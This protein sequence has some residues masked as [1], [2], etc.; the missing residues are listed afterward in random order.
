MSK[1]LDFE[2]YQ[3]YETKSRIKSRINFLGKNAFNQEKIL[4][5]YFL[6]KSQKNIKK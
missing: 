2:I 4:K 5:Y 3:I 1:K 6:I